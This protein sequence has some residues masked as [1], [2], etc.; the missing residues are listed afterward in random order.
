MTKM[1]TTIRA[2]LFG[3]S[4]KTRVHYEKRG[5]VA[6]LTLSDENL[7]GYTYKMFRDLDDCILQARFDPQIQVIVITGAGEHFCAVAVL[8]LPAFRA[9]L[10]GPRNW[11]RAVCE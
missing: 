3:D 1:T 9:A 7:N 11:G 4:D 5:A 10:V 6:L 2:D 8:L